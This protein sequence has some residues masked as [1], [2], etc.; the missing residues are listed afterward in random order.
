LPAERAK[1][2]FGFD[3]GLDPNSYKDKG[4]SVRYYSILCTLCDTIGICKFN[5]RWV[6]NPIGIREMAEL[7]YS[8]TGVRMDEEQM[9]E[10]AER[11][12]NVER[13]FLVREGIT[14]ADDVIEGRAMDEPVPSGP[15]KGERLDREAFSG[16]LDDYYEAVGW[17]KKTGIPTRATLSRWASKT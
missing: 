2:M 14:R 10:V 5:T 15:Y 11:I 17:D 12:N 8:T 13:A 6:G 7:L 16:M 9:I 3:K 4:K 1:A